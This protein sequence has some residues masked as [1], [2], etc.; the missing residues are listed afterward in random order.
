MRKDE[1]FEILT[2]WNFWA[3][4]IDTGILRAKYRDKLI[5]LIKKQLL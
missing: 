1:L 4:E 3:K 5:E 2:D